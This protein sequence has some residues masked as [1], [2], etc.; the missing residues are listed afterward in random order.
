MKY[1][2]NIFKLLLMFLLVAMLSIFG[3]NRY[4]CRVGETYMTEVPKTSDAVIVLG[5]SVFGNT[6]SHVLADRLDEAY[7]VYCNGYAPKIIVSGDHGTKDYNEVKAM[8]DYLVKKGVPATDIFMDHAG[9]STYDTVYRAKEIFQVKKAII[10]TQEDHLIRALYIANRL[11]LPA[12]G[13]SAGNYPL[14]EAAVQ[15][16]REPLARIKAF[17]QC[18]ILHPEPEFLGEPIP[19]STMDGR[20]TEG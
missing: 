10:V 11:G 3:I 1:I 12:E 9:F 17:L 13:I 6:V 20:V 5:A 19:V 18:E 4:V 16:I 2:K 14:G 8:R 7:D 15:K